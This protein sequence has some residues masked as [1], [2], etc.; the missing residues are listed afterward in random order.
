MFKAKDVMKTDLITVRRQTEIHEAIRILVENNITGL[1]VVNDDMSLAGIIS[2]KDMLGLLYNIED[3]PGNVEDFMTENVV[4][5]DQ[6]DSLID[7]AESFIASSF[8]RVP[9]VT[10]GKLVGIISRK[11]IIAYILKLR[12]K[13]KAAV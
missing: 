13:D 8:R 1:P 7:V 12:H 9:I 10:E 3:K 6:E 4:C 2:E 5:F 11:D